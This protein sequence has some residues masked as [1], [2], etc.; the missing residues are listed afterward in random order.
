MQEYYEVQSDDYVR[1]YKGAAE[2]PEHFSAGEY[3]LNE[4]DTFK[5]CTFAP[6]EGSRRTNENG[7]APNWTLAVLK[8]C[9]RRV[10]TT[11]YYPLPVA[12]GAPTRLPHSVHEPS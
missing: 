5:T 6:G 7:K 1:P 4:V 11:R 8:F 9:R 3:S 2:G 12:T 10:T